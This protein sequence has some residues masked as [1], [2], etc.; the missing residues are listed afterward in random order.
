MH[1]DLGAAGLISVENRVKETGSDDQRVAFVVGDVA[2]NVE[3]VS[4]AAVAV[5]GGG[6]SQIQKESVKRPRLPPS[7]ALTWAAASSAL[8]D[9]RIPSSMRSLLFISLFLSLHSV[10]ATDGI[11]KTRSIDV[12][13]PRNYTAVNDARTASVIQ[14]KCHGLQWDKVSVSAPDITDQHTLAQLARM[15]ANAYALPGAPNWWDL[16]PMWSS[17]RIFRFVDPLHR[18][19]LKPLVVVVPDRMGEPNRWLPW[20]RFRKPGQ[21]HSRPL[22]QG[23]NT[24]RTHV[25]GRQTERQPHVFVLLCSS[26]PHMGVPDRMRLLRQTFTM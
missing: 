10:S 17:V 19:H 13:R 18:T 7:P 4:V 2:E 3:V 22:D 11:F 6:K 23:H 12:F 21:Q 14:Q 16:D 9:R 5:E 8:L 1:R 26:R 15:A 20:P 25:Q 24:Q